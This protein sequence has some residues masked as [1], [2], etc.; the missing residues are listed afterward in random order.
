[1]T[2]ISVKQLSMIL[3]FKFLSHLG[4]ILGGLRSTL[5][6]WKRNS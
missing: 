4:P 2:A 1:M 6:L 5:H 3:K